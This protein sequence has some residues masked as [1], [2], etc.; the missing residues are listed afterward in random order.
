MKTTKIANITIGGDVIHCSYAANVLY[1]RI[2]MWSR[3]TLYVGYRY[4]WREDCL[5]YRKND[6]TKVM[7]MCDCSLVMDV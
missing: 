2:I 5:T 4:M 1:V 3:V 6:G 7:G